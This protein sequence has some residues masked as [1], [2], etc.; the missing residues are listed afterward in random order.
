MSYFQIGVLLRYVA[1]N[2]ISFPLLQSSRE[3]VYEVHSVESERGELHLGSR[4]DYDLIVHFCGL[5]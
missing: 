2:S 5:L 4:G 3:L 1:S